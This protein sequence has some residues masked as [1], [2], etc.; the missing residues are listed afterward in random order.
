MLARVPALDGDVRV[1]D[2]GCGKGELLVRALARF[3]G[4]GVGVEPNPAFATE[5]RARIRE[6][7][8][9]GAAHIVEASWEHA[10][11]AEATF[12]FAICTGSLH[13]F[14]AW[15]DALAGMSR[16]VSRGGWALLGPGYWKRP[17]HADYPA[18]F[19]GRADELDSLA[20][21]L[22]AALAHGW[23]VEAC[24]E[25]TLAEWDAYELGYATR[26]REWCAANPDD[27]DAA[28]FRERIRTWSDA[29]ARW[30]RDTLGYA[31]VL[32]HRTAG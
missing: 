11:L 22:A 8:A 32:L 28:A 19:G 18:A 13:A 24:H 6:R 31:L 5:A 25:S 7:L 15:R 4:T 10:A 27:A 21:T 14:G 23:R 9:P 2:V 12:T 29:Y 1:L 20:A 17:P 26:M 3:G 30:G 16:V